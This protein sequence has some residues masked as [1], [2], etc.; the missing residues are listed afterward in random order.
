MLNDSLPWKKKGKSK[1]TL[2]KQS[3]QLH[4]LVFSKG[5]ENLC[6][7]KNWHKDVYDSFIH[8]FQNLE[9]TKM[10]SGR[11]MGKSMVVLMEYYSL[12]KQNKIPIQEN[13]WKKLKCVLINERS[14]CER[15]Y[16]L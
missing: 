15:L 12:L 4:S 11:W 6:P 10:S 9:A 13:I 5:V 3:S 1:H 7:H 8:S 16:T 14:Q 2:T